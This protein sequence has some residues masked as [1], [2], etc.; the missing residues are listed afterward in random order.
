VGLFLGLLGAAAAVLAVRGY[1]LMAS[2]GVSLHFIVDDLVSPEPRPRRTLVARLLDSLD[3]VVGRRVL[4]RATDPVLRRA[5]RILAAAGYP[6]GFTAERLIARQASWAALGAVAG[7]FLVLAGNLLGL[8]VPVPAWFLPRALVWVAGRRRQHEI[9]RDLPDFLDVLTVSIG[10]GLGFRSALSRVAKAVG[11]PVG[12]EMLTA[13]RQI[14]LG[15]SRRRAFEQVRE[16]NS[17][18]AMGHFVTAF[19]QSEELGSPLGDFLRVYAAEMRRDAGQ[20]ARTAAAR[21]NP[22]I[23][24]AITLVIVPAI[25]IFMI[26]SLL[27][28]TFLA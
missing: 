26:G 4:A 25:T 27:V 22:K 24:M 6:N 11:G 12:Q 16:R 5:D 8:L 21:A 14:E 18:Q 13:L 10:A 2:P 23:S 20:R 17:S 7:S 9:D 15:A 28:G 19:L 1:R 3:R